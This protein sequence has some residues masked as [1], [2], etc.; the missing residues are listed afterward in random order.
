MLQIE[1]RYQNILQSILTKYP[2]SFYVYGSR[3]KG[4]VSKFSDLDLCYWEEIPG[5]TV[6][7]IN[8]ELADSH[9]P[10]VV[11]IVNWKHMRPAFQKIIQKDLTLISSPVLKSA[12]TSF[13]ISKTSKNW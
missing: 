4:T 7:E 1:K 8:W 9:L 5:H 10:F 3:V 11:E 6:A 12:K 2:Y 13:P